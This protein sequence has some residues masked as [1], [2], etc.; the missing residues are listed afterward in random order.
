MSITASYVLRF[1]LKLF[2]SR[3]VNTT[4]TPNTRAAFPDATELLV[5]PLAIE[6]TRSGQ[7]SRLMIDQRH[8]AVVWREGCVFAALRCS[9]I[10][11]HIHLFD[12]LGKVALSQSLVVFVC[13]VHLF[14][15]IALLSKLQYPAILATRGERNKLHVPVRHPGVYHSRTHAHCRRYVRAGK[16]LIVR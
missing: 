10:L 5:I 4:G 15:T 16:Q 7:H 1:P 9:V 13:S 12:W 11:T 3:V 6:V 2:V 14:G 8:D